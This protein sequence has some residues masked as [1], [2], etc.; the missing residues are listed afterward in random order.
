MRISAMHF[1]LPSIQPKSTLNGPFLQNKLNKSD[2]FEF[3]SNLREVKDDNGNVIHRNSTWF[4]RDDLKWNEFGDYLVEKYKDTPKV[5]VYCYACSDGSEPYSLAMLLIS[6]LGEQG[7]KKFFP[8]MAKDYDEEI[9]KD[10]KSPFFSVKRWDINRIN[11]F[12]D[13]NQDKFIDIIAK[14]KTNFVISMK[15]IL[16]D[17][18]VFEQSDIT[19]DLKSVK[20]ENS[21]IMAR[22]FW[23]Y[24]PSELVLD[25]ASEFANRV[26]DNSLC[27]IGKYDEDQTGMNY[28]LMDEYLKPTLI[29]YCFER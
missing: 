13:G 1:N 12:S 15:P 18:V 27:V 7:A 29:D 11:Y 25:V 19:E 16:Q 23:G 14:N 24:L 2:S 26:G 17:T 6:K 20:T 8:I 28:L 4:F 9:I 10:A 3:T 22:N 5:N 21:V